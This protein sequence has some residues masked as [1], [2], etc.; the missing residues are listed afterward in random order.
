MI[1]TTKL[2]ALHLWKIAV[3]YLEQREYTQDD[4]LELDHD[5][6]S[7][8][9][10]EEHHADFTND[11][12]EEIQLL[13]SRFREAIFP[14]LEHAKLLSAYEKSASIFPD[15]QW[16]RHLKDDERYKLFA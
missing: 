13:D 16:W 6:S 11:E 10:I 9:L 5:I 2:Q 7:R 3:Q 15:N 4:W 12:L 1:K 8:S 14:A